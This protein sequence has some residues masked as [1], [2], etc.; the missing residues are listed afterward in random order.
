MCVQLKQKTKKPQQ[1]QKPEKCISKEGWMFVS[2]AVRRELVSSRWWCGHCLT[3]E[4][5]YLCSLMGLIFSP[6]QNITHSL[7]ALFISHNKPLRFDLSLSS[8][9]TL[10][11]IWCEF[12]MPFTLFL[13]I[14]FLSG[15][16]C[17]IQYIWSTLTDSLSCR[18]VHLWTLLSPSYSFSSLFLYLSFHFIRRFSPLL[19][20]SLHD[21][22]EL[23]CSW[24]RNP[25]WTLAWVRDKN[26]AQT[27]KAKE[28]CVLLIRLAMFMPARTTGY[29]DW[30]RWAR[31]L[32]RVS[33]ICSLIPLYVT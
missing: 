22:W 14:S 20:Q 26:A 1:Q 33:I 18:F 12:S 29:W 4:Y 32:S 5:A 10:Y 30:S 9:R 17:L 21:H 7:D 19:P 3:W 28:P 25:I 15:L 8:P 6:S 23:L 16:C 2:T 24:G 31:K 27:H 13:Q 11:W